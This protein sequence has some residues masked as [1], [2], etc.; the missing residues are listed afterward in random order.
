MKMIFDDLADALNSIQALES[1]NT[2]ICITDTDHNMIYETSNKNCRPSVCPEDLKKIG[3]VFRPSLRA[4]FRVHLIDNWV[5]AITTIPV[6]IGGESYLLEFKQ[7]IRQNIQFSP[8]PRDLEDLY[9]HQ[10]KEMAITDSLTK[11]YNRRYIDERLPID[12]QSSF[13]LDEPLSVL[14]ID[15]DYFKR[16]NDQNGHAAGDQVLQKLALLLQKH[17]RKGS[18]WV[19]RYGGDEILIS[20][21]GSGKKAAKSIANRLRE[22]VQNYNFYFKGKK[23]MVTCSI[24]TQTVFKDSGV[25]G[26]AEL[27]AMVDKKLYRA[28]NEGRNRVC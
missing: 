28:K 25:A 27:L 12:M 11:L 3:R 20:L 21:P 8:E 26:I 24:G 5:T 15:I 18:G 2:L 16:I 23:V 1:V 17:L 7:L 6:A 22:T 10:I 9:I 13:E 4:T 14:F 19:A